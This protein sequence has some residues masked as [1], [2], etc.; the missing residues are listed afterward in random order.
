MIET[1]FCTECENNVDINLFT[2]KNA[3]CKPCLAKITKK[4]I[5]NNKERSKENKLRW[6]K[7]NIEKR[8]TNKRLW[9]AKR[10]KEN[11]IYKFKCNLRSLIWISFHKKGFKKDSKL[12]DI[13]GCD[14][15]FFKNYIESQFTKN[16]N[17]DNIHLDHIKP[18][19]S[20]KS[21]KEVLDLNHYTNF[22]PLLA[23][24]NLKKGVSIIEK[25]LKL[26]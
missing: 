8:R 16:M 5:E 2:K 6:A 22:Q 13:L 11:P 14:F 19:S 7:Q 15:E 10:K 4:W 12:N 21:K 17:W 3:K 18:L 20:A 26:L 23:I 25:Q 24:D 9:E 1:K